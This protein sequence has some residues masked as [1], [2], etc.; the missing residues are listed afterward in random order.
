MMELDSTITLIGVRL[1]KVGLEFI[2]K[3]PAPE[4]EECRFKN[5]CMNLSTG[6]KYR[7]VNVRTSTQHSCYV[8]DEGVQ[9]VEVVESPII[10]AIESKKAFKGSKVVFEPPSC[11]RGECTIYDLCH[12]VGVEFGDKCTISEVIGDTPEECAKGLSLKVVELKH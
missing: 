2:F 5:S 1:A 8:H 3:G 4:C 6:R 11:K 12:P 7:I 9:A 10:S